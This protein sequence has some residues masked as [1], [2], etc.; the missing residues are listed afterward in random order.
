MSDP[1]NSTN[2]SYV[3][4]T[5]PVIKTG[6]LILRPFTI[7]DVDSIFR[8]ASSPKVAEFTT[9][10]HNQNKEDSISFLKEY[11][12]KMYD[13]EQIEPLAITFKSDPHTAIGTVGC[14]WSTKQNL[15]M[16]LAYALHHDFWSQGIVAE[17]CS[18]L[19]DYCFTNTD[20]QKVKSHCIIENVGSYKV[21]EKIG[22]K[23]EGTFRAHLLIKEQFRDLV[24]Y[25]ILKNEWLDLE[26]SGR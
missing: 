17:A 24:F 1:I 18:A 12:F 11:A 6:R 15:S 21:M 10:N 14:P 7:E 9:W 20:V 26:R 19:I 13:S 23:H 5:P 22:M 3:M 25:A 16:E 4:W 2:E 8:Y